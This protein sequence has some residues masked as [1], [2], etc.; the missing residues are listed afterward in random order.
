V[1]RPSDRHWLLENC[2]VHYVNE[3]VWQ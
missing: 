2:V 3:H 1:M